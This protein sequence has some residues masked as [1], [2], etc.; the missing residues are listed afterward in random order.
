[1]SRFHTYKDSET[2]PNRASKD[3]ILV[4]DTDYENKARVQAEL[5]RWL[6]QIGT[7][8]YIRSEPKQTQDAASI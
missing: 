3:V 8:Y 2:Y 6:G 1:M 4:T 7:F 5:D